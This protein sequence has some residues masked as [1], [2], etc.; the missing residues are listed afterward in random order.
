M[1]E[2]LTAKRIIKKVPWCILLILLLVIRIRYHREFPIE[3]FA[4][5]ILVIAFLISYLMIP[6]MIVLGF[7]MGILD[8]PDNNRKV[9]S[10]A[11]PQT[12]GIAIYCGFIAAMFLGGHCSSNMKNIL[13]AGSSIFII[14]AIDDYKSISSVIRI[15]FQV[16]AS[17]FLI[18]N[19]IRISFIPV[20]LGGVV[21][22]SIIT[23]IWIV[24]ITNAMN[25]IDGMDGLAAGMSI[26]FSGFFSLISLSTDQ[27]YFMYCAL[28]LA[29]ACSG[30][31]PY[32]FRRDRPA[33]IFLGD[34]GS[35]FI[36]FILAASAIMGEWGNTIVDL[37]IPAIIMSI[38]IF[39]MFL[40]TTVRIAKGEVTSF[41]TWLAYTGRDHVHHRLG[42]LGLGKR[43][44]VYMYYCI[45]FGF[46]LTSLI[47]VNSTWVISLIAIMQSVLLLVSLGI[48]LFKTTDKTYIKIINNLVPFNSRRFEY[49]KNKDLFKLSELIEIK[50]DI[51][52]S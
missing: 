35:T 4:P 16:G 47:I 22:E 9:H 1:Q 18:I 24:G 43:K 2:P 41:K 27:Y 6:F 39:D 32:N 40:T 52:S 29:G 31:L 8:N 30:F 37:S 21:T 45:A 48:I 10:H 3:L 26:I 38:L 5:F 19:G 33:R 13:F 23:L 36:G 25:F 14:G 20:W 46:G 49:E 7:K 15:I 44:T 34:A 50:S 17:L 51:H 11:T 42:M 28:A 12:G